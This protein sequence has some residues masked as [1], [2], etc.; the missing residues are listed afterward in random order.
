MGHRIPE[1]QRNWGPHALASWGGGGLR[2][3]VSFES[4]FEMR[5]SHVS[6][7]FISS[8]AV[9]GRVMDPLTASRNPRGLFLEE[10]VSQASGCRHRPETAQGAWKRSINRGPSIEGMGRVWERGFSPDGVHL[11]G[12]WSSNG[13]GISSSS[14]P[15]PP[16]AT[17]GIGA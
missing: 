13:W 8:L 11:K 7:R 17:R 16:W 12:V 5:N 6:C 2:S 15:C 3:E 10:V 4:L 14:T 1:M 9:R